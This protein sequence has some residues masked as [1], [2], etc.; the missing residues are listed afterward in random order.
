M[1][2]RKGILLVVAGL[3]GAVG[4]AA[5]ASGAAKA[6]HSFATYA[7][8][9]VPSGQQGTTAEGYG[10]GTS[11]TTGG[12]G[13]MTD[14]AFGAFQVSLATSYPSDNATWRVYGNNRAP[15]SSPLIAFVVCAS[16]YDLR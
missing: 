8:T 5:L 16:G 14:Q 6:P 7:W 1:S 13:G 11:K 4:A 9:T 10:G 12:G 3:I 15:D 2:W